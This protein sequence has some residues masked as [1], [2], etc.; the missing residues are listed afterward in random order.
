MGNSKVFT[1]IEIFQ[2]NQLFLFN[3]I[4]KYIHY[5]TQPGPQSAMRYV[6]A[7]LNCQYYQNETGKIDN[8]FELE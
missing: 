2:F 4:C 1:E 3:L 7:Y 8:F 6:R 5:C